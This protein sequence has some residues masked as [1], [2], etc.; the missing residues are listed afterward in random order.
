M[1]I[2]DKLGRA[3]ASL[4]HVQKASFKFVFEVVVEHV[5]KVHAQ[6]Y[7]GVPLL[8]VVQKR[9][10]VYATSCVTCPS[11]KAATVAVSFS[12]T[13]ALDLTLFG[14]PLQDAE[15]EEQRLYLLKKAMQMQRASGSLH[16]PL[17]SGNEK[18]KD[19]VVFLEK[20]LKVALRTHEANGKTVG[21]VHVD[22]SKW[23]RV[24]SGS[25]TERL[26]LSNGSVLFLKVKSRLVDTA[27]PGI[28][29]GKALSSGSSVH[30]S[31]WG[32]GRSKSGK[33]LFGR[34]K[35]GGDDD[36][37]DG[38]SSFLGGTSIADS[39]EWLNNVED[40]DDLLDDGQSPHDKPGSSVLNE[41]GRAV[42]LQTS[43]H[44]QS[45][46][47]GSKIALDHVQASESSGNVAA[48][49][50]AQ[51]RL[52]EL[53]EENKRI[54]DATHS[55]ADATARVEREMRMVQQ[56]MDLQDVED[57]DKL[58]IADLEKQLRVLVEKNELLESNIYTIEQELGDAGDKAS[59]RSGS[60]RPDQAEQVKRDIQRLTKQLE[61]DTKF[62][63]AIEELKTTKLAYAIA[64]CDLEEARYSIR[65]QQR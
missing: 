31:R 46:T 9:D 5:D 10:H 39:D 11:S 44:E 48:V 7:A 8:V 36:V 3:G 14:E 45:S 58:S 17:A 61:K 37:D 23:A 60:G 27:K 35:A 22:A 56:E 21:K 6:A 63:D 4:S 15:A 65:L 40:L 43:E 34:K 55:I 49:R 12:E 54:L 41:M 33:S 59:T 52:Q 50:D 42:S 13:I 38:S 24:P 18:G 19:Q 47:K 53:E 32:R 62:L 20:D 1:M 51:Q 2:K 57:C 28:K 26:T 25:V 64:L 29:S 30:S 16:S